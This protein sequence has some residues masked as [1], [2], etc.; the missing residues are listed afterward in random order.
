[1]VDKED[2]EEV[3]HYY[4]QNP[5]DKG[6]QGTRGERIYRKAIGG[7]KSFVATTAPKI[8]RV[9]ATGKRT[10]KKARRQLQRMED[11]FPAYSG[12]VPGFG[13][14]ASNSYGENL[15]RIGS[16]WN[17]FQFNLPEPPSGNRRGRLW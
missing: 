1:M 8:Q 16:D 5:Q 4:E 9:K 12:G 6:Y 17:N 13:R 10:S 11:N 14:T 2:K 7:L 15:M 3:E